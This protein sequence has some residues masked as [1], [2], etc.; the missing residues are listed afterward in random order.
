MVA[1]VSQG[2][3][4][5]LYNLDVHRTASLPRGWHCLNLHDG[6]DKRSEYCQLSSTSSTPSSPRA[7]L[8]RRGSTLRQGFFSYKKNGLPPAPPVRK[9]SLEQQ[10]RAAS[11]PHH[12][13]EGVTSGCVQTNAGRRGFNVDSGR[14]F[15]ARL[16]QLANRTHS[17]GRVQR[18]NNSSYHYDCLSLER[19][20]SLRGGGGVRGDSTMPRAG[21]NLSRA[22]SLSSSGANT[23][24]Q[25]FRAGSGSSSAP[26]SPAHSSSQSRLSAV[27]KLLLSS[28]PKGRSLS[29]SSSKAP[30]LSN[31]SLSQTAGRS[32]SGKVGSAP[33]HVTFVQ[34]VNDDSSLLMRQTSVT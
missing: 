19:G 7:T 1:M 22:G 33:L 3:S 34:G 9:S 4:L 8:D 6:L 25:A 5:N 28:S 10:S 32:S 29:T 24:H 20:E 23:H 21:H 12:R 11:P 18:S 26:Q 30:S 14:L 13:D 15:S 2:E 16:E 27:S 17:L 31:K